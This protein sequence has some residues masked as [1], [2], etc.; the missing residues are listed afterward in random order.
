[1]G[2]ATWFRRQSSR[3]LAL[4]WLMGASCSVLVDKDRVQCR[5]DSECRD[6]GPESA[7]AVC[8]DSVCQPDPVWGC[9]GAVVWPKPPPGMFTVTIHLR[10]LID[11]KPIAG[12]TGRLCEKLDT[13]CKAPLGPDLTADAAGDLALPVR[14]GFDGYVEMRAP[15]K[16]PGIYFFY[17]PV[18]MNREI[19]FVPLMEPQLV[20]QLALLNGKELRSDRGHVLLGGYDCQRKPAEGIHLATDDAD[21]STAGFYVL[22]NVPK[23]GAQ[24]TDSS[25]RGG[26]INLREGI[27]AITAQLAADNRKLA[28]VSLFV[29]PGMLTFTSIVPAPR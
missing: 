9:L 13:G 12:A 28:T 14:S 26:F 24:A 6:R 21:E 4:V 10:D 22:N 5:A 8:I 3:V 7:G 18:D 25:G 15:D 16:M 29:R 19:Q 20:E 2:S 1:M 17:P 23:A 11:G 27:V